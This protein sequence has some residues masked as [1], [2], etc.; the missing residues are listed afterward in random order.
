MGTQ[1][2][3]IWAVLFPCHLR[4]S[5][6]RGSG[7]GKELPVGS[8]GFNSEVAVIMRKLMLALTDASLLPDMAADKP[9]ALGAPCATPGSSARLLRFQALCL[10]ISFSNSQ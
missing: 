8:G 7:A 2:P 5:L 3:Q 4:G 1:I 10:N 9:N 6:G